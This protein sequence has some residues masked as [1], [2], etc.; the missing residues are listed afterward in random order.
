MKPYITFKSSI[1][2]FLLI[3]IFSGLC[4]LVLLDDN[5]DRKF[6][7]IPFIIGIGICLISSYVKITDKI[8]VIEDEL[9]I[10]NSQKN[11]KPRDLI[12]LSS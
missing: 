8:K 5:E 1:V 12:L 4:L 11:V 6:L 9:K 2:V 7:Y 3:L 10:T